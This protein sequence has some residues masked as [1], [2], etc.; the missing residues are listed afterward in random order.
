MDENIIH[1]IKRTLEDALE[2]EDWKCVEE[3]LELINDYFYD[4]IEEDTESL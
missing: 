4:S 1:D 2:C 3:A